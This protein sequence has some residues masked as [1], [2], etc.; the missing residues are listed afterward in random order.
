LITSTTAPDATNTGATTLTGD[1]GVSPAASITGQATLTV[2]GINALLN[3]SH[4]H[5]GDATA[6]LAQSQLVTAKN[7]LASLSPGTLEPAILGNLSLNPVVYSFTT[8]AQLNGTL[9]LNGQGNANAAWVFLIPTALTT[10]S[11]AVVDVINTG[12]GAGVFWDV[13]SQATLGTTTSFE[14]NILAGTSIILDHGATINCGRAL[15]STAEVTMDNNV[16]NAADCIGTGEEGSNGLSGGLVVNG[17]EVSLLPFAPINAPTN[18][19]PEPGTLA[20]FG[21][22]LA[23]L[24][25]VRKKLPRLA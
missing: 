1:V 5:L 24:F 23:G 21:F 2:D 14:G 8:T 10:A 16:V 12:A 11:G 4:V 19:V 17:R 3:P 15:A 9:T 18:G 7:N 22:G 13:G 20:L 6:G 25:G